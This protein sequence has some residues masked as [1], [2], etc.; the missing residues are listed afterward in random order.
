VHRVVVAPAALAALRSAVALV[1]PA[2]LLLP[3]PAL[4]L[5]LVP[6]ERPVLVAPAVLAVPVVL[7]ATSGSTSMLSAICS[8][9]S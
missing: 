9:T 6:V 3:V 8:S 7:R 2:V 1:V 4:G 5:V